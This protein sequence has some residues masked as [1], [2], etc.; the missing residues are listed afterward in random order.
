MLKEKKVFA[1]SGMN[2]DTDARSLPPNH[3][4]YALNILSNNSN[5]SNLGCIETAKATPLFLLDLVL[6]QTR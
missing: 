1:Q 6:E 2:L 3:Y 5:G 4:G